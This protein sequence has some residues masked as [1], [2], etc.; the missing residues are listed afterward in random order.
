VRS[1]IKAPSVGAT[2][3][4]SD[5]RVLFAVL[6]ALLALGVF[7]STATSA[8]AA[9]PPH[10]FYSDAFVS[11]FAT[12]P[13]AEVPTTPT[14]PFAST[15]HLAFDNSR[16]LLFN[17]D[18]TNNDI[19][20]FGAEGTTLNPQ[21]AAGLGDL[22]S[23]FGV[24]VDQASQ[25]LYVA[26]A[27]NS[28]VVRYSISATEPPAYTLDPGF[29]SPEAGNEP[30]QLGTF[31]NALAV[32]PTTH[33]L[34]VVD[35]VNHRVD[36]YASDG[37][38]ISAFDGSTGAGGTF[39]GPTDVAAAA[40]GSVYVTDT[41]PGFFFETRHSRLEHFS[42][43]GTSLGAVSGL[44]AAQYL[45]YNPSFDM[46]NVASQFVS[47]L[48]TQTF[49]QSYTPELGGFIGPDL[50]EVSQ[51][52][53]F[54]NHTRVSGLAVD[55]QASGNVYLAQSFNGSEGQAI[56]IYAP[57]AVLA[58]G[59]SIDAPTEVT[60][61]TSHI[62]G[63]IDAGDAEATAHTSAHF[64]YSLDRQ[65]WT[66][67]P[68]LS[69]SG[70]GAQ[71]VSADLTELDS[72]RITYVRLV[73]RRT[74][75]G[76]ASGGPA[77]TTSRVASISTPQGPPR[78]TEP[79]LRDL[80][81][82]MASLPG[83][84]NPF[85]IQGSYHFEYGLTDAYGSRS[86]VGA[87][88]VLG[89][90]A[91][92]KPVTAAV[93]GL[94]PNTTYHYRLVATN[95]AGT[96]FGPDR[97]FTT[98]SVSTTATSRAFEQVTPVDKGGSLMATELGFAVQ[99]D[100]SAAE[101]SIVTLTTEGTFPGASVDGGVF[102]HYAAT[103]GADGWSQQLLEVPFTPNVEV[104]PGKSTSVLSGW[105]LTQRPA[106]L[107]HSIV[108]SDHVLASG[109]VAGLANFYTEDHRTGT[110]TFLGSLPS[111][112]FGPLASGAI[113]FLSWATPDSTHLYVQGDD[114]YYEL[115]NGQ[116]TLVSK[117]IAGLPLPNYNVPISQEQEPGNSGRTRL[118]IST[119]SGDTVVYSSSTE[120]AFLNHEGDV[121]PISVSERPG[122]SSTP[123]P[124]AEAGFTEDGNAVFFIEGSE[125][126]LT[127]GGGSQPGSPIYRYSLDA[128]EGHRLTYIGGRGGVTF[129]NL[130]MVS[131]DGETVVFSSPEGLMAWRDGHRKLLSA[132]YKG[133]SQA[134]PDVSL[135][136]NGRYL[137][138]RSEMH[139]TSDQTISKAACTEEFVRTGECVEI[140][141][142]DL[143]A[144][145]VTC[146]SCTAD[147]SPPAGDAELGQEGPQVVTDDGEAFFATP[148]KLVNSDVNGANDVYSYKSGLVHLI[149][150][151][152][153]GTHTRLNGASPSGRDVFILTDDRLVSQDTDDAQDL[154]DARVGGGFASQNPAPAVTPCSGA[155]CRAEAPASQSLAAA[156][157]AAF[158]GPRDVSRRGRKRCGKGSHAAKARS[159]AHCVKKQKKKKRAHGSG[160]QGR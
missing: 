57:H 100:G 141:L 94:E 123:V 82:T 115:A 24:A 31:A 49:E 35:P 156:G 67:L 143:D 44:G 99:S 122:D 74:D 79:P 1:Q 153:L 136:P 64:E 103:R 29:T 21:P 108:C 151:G 126:P 158:N 55:T 83:S 142:F 13:E 152:T 97:Q 32:D 154:Y 56:Q 65:S 23:P 3:G 76:E 92:P 120:G 93:A 95:A 45:A 6:S 63:T 144:D 59:V 109:A 116:T 130:L 138:L 16:H 77:R 117:T 145:T 135:S 18:A 147:G 69:L 160:R 128:P 28:R 110:L 46:A 25:F 89:A 124:V 81:A 150:R 132:A 68:D 41:Q 84:V 43:A 20:V 37:T 155:G 8:L 106:D 105:V 137:V 62:T 71:P 54:G 9:Q 33:D 139:L 30:G 27:G 22:L 131:A 102:S 146:V 104:A 96:T 98:D 101:G 2:G 5:S 121:T 17:V 134:R 90:V 40:D 11:V 107:H 159:R 50:T 53:Q 48:N 91:E 70:A 34:L 111:G 61:I 60:A 42:A 36:R 157:S 148:T 86:P 113:A 10:P 119:P 15:G 75:D 149:S 85:G 112:V 47:P 26:D 19:A 114:G 133:V 72:N 52:P 129:H 87:D 73:A 78:V 80:T 12:A 118:P 51:D 127:A 66:A 39:V 140:Y 4:R 88:A 125:E 38:F 14:T 58:P 7:A